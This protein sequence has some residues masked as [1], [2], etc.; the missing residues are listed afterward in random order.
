LFS[1]INIE[2]QK[3]ERQIKY[4]KEDFAKEFLESYSG[5]LDS[6]GLW[7]TKFGRQYAQKRKRLRGNSLEATICEAKTWEFLTGNRR[8]AA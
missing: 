2:K 7:I 5:I 8:G 4:K 6:Y 3:V 1:N